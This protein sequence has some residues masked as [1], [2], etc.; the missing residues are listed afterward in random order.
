M[1]SIVR[2]LPV[3]ALCAWV[4]LGLAHTLIV[5]GG[6][7]GW[8]PDRSADGARAVVGH[9]DD[10]SPVLVAGPRQL[11]ETSAT[12]PAV[13][14]A[15]VLPAATDSTSLLYARYQLSNVLY[16][17]RVFVRRALAPVV[18]DDSALFVLGPGIDA[19]DGCR[20]AASAYGFRRIECTR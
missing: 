20:P 6:P 8:R 10:T 3:L 9:P 18:V 5:L 11:V 17:R 4:V 13:P 19:P 1:G 15:L 12:R 16:P 2:R 7:R 14:L